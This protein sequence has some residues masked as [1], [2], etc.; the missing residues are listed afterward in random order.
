MKKQKKENIDVKKI[1]EKI[2][3]E[4]ILVQVNTSKG[5]GAKCQ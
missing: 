2:E 1:K 3:L 4:N 5:V